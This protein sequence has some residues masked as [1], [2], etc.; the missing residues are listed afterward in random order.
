MTGEIRRQRELL[1]ID[2]LQSGLDLHALALEAESPVLVYL[3]ELLAKRA[4]EELGATAQIVEEE[5]AAAH[6][7]N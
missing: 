2:I 6:P 5:A 7:I 4:R 3:A 1:L